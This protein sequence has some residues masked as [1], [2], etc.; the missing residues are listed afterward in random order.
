MKKLDFIFGILLVSILGIFGFLFLTSPYK[1]YSLLENRFLERKPRIN[2]F[3]K[4]SIQLLET[5]YQ[6]QFLYRSS[7]LELGVS[8]KKKLGIMEIS[9]IYLGKDEYLLEKTEPLKQREKLISI[10]NDFHKTHND[11]NMALLLLPSHIT[12]RPELVNSK[13]PIFD[14]YEQ[15]KAIYH[16]ITFNTIDVVPTLKEGSKEYEMYYHLDSHLTS[17]GAYY[18]YQKFAQLSDFNSLGL[19][20]F[21]IEEVTNQFSGNLVKVA[22][23]FSWKKD[24]IVKFVPKKELPLEVQYRKKKTNTLYDDEALTTNYPYDYFLGKTEP[25]VVIT[26]K[27][28][29]PK[30]LLV[31]KDDSANAMIPFLVT[32][33]SKIHVIDTNFYHQSIEEYLKNQPEIKDVIFIYGFHNL[34]KE[35]GNFSLK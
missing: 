33:Y 18:V 4:N 10:F 31:V 25:V 35:I 14:E 12:I 34:H 11:L 26:N 27:Q 23:T 29:E 17:Y 2:F 21:D 13:A 6:D 15:I 9:G 8:L 24:R 3:S 1:P 28:A 7:F 30:E 20:H 16:N 22:H 19:E 5:F 32:H